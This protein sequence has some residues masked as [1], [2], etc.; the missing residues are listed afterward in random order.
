MDGVVDPGCC[1]LVCVSSL[2]KRGRPMWRSY[3]CV[4]LSGPLWEGQGFDCVYRGGSWGEG[5]GCVQSGSSTAVCVTVQASKCEAW[6]LST[7]ASRCLGRCDAVRWSPC[8]LHSFHCEQLTLE[9]C[10][11]VQSLSL[12]PGLSLNKPEAFS[13][14]LQWEGTRA[15]QKGAFSPRTPPP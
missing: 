15:S 1:A 3:L 11:W 13:G 6:L 7:T 4:R 8:S 9:V 14:P 12:V 2:Q 5:G 10:P